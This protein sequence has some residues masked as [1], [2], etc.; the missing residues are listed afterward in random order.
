[1]SSLNEVLPSATRYPIKLLISSTETILPL[2]QPTAIATHAG[3][4]LPIPVPNWFLYHGNWAKAL[5]QNIKTKTKKN[6]FFS[7]V[8]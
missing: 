8:R 4:Q 3:P 1:M 6:N 7:Y 2:L 5:R